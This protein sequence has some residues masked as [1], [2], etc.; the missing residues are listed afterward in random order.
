MAANLQQQR[1]INHQLR[2][3]VD[4]PRMQVSE[5]CLL[6]MKYISDHESDDCLLNGFT[7]QKVN[8]FREKAS[9][10]IL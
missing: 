5:A 3:E 8:P 7:S 2:R 6:I 1:I 10:A 4:V 9:C